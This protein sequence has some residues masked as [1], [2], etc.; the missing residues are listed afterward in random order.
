M[1]FEIQDIENWLFNMNGATPPSGA[2][3]PHSRLY[4]RQ[5]QFYAPKQETSSLES[6][7][8]GVVSKRVQIHSGGVTDIRI[9]AGKKGAVATSNN[10][11]LLTGCGF[12]VAKAIINAAGAGLQTEVY[13]RYGV[14]GVME[15]PQYGKDNYGKS[16]GRGY[17]IS[18]DS[19]DMRA[20]HNI[21]KIEMLTVPYLVG[22]E[23][24][25]GVENMYYEAFVHNKDLDYMIV[26]MAGMSHPL[27]E[28]SSDKSA[29]LTMNA[30]ERF[31]RDYPDSKLNLV[32]AIFNDKQAEENYKKH[33]VAK[34]A[35]LAKQLEAQ[36]K[37]NAVHD[38]PVVAHVKP[39]SSSP[40]EEKSEGSKFIHQSSDTDYFVTGVEKH[41]NGYKIHGAND[42]GEP[43]Y[44]I[45]DEQGNARGHNGPQLGYVE[46]QLFTNRKAIFKQYGIEEPK[47]HQK[48]GAQQVNK[49]ASFKE[50]HTLQSSA[51]KDKAENIKWANAANKLGYLDA[52][53]FDV[54]DSHKAFSFKDGSQAALFAKKFPH[55][56]T[57]QEGDYHKVVLNKSQ[58][59]N[60]LQPA[61]KSNLSQPNV[62]AAQPN[63]GMQS[64]FEKSQHQDK[65]RNI[66][67][68]E[69][70]KKVGYNN[71]MVFDCKDSKGSSYKEFSFKDG[72]QA[73]DFAKIA[74]AATAQAG[75]Y[76][77]VILSK[78]QVLTLQHKLQSRE[79]FLHSSKFDEHVTGFK[80][81]T[82]EMSANANENANYAKAHPIASQFC[83]GLEAAG[84]R[85]L[86]TGDK[87]A[88]KSECQHLCSKARNSSL[89]DHR[90][91]TGAI[92]KFVIDVLSV[93]TLGLTNRLSMFT[94]TDSV[95]KVDDFEQTVVNNL[96]LN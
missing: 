15:T 12:A 18:C 77:Q 23:N 68:A 4:G 75:G 70:I 25:D 67:L 10:G 47:P 50:A 44:V 24:E 58:L 16:E 56:A 31:V 79:A 37:Q 55:V 20:T 13:N 57:Y 76:H 81:K 45:I 39:T 51:A 86:K 22:K 87:Q 90:E 3:L 26:P 54:K 94:R 66:H 8:D 32:C 6:V 71:V 27:L 42:K 38:Q 69:A 14:P 63:A 1:K 59:N 82:K 7:G 29:R 92:A 84:R 5:Q 78:Q 11:D 19:Y 41:G 93:I 9:A 34:D 64:L 65:Q 89:K 96:S 35:I 21:D 60:L 61:I 80:A 74:H 88:L 52:W 33:V 17:A 53:V 72:K 83:S 36:H 48:Q 85:Y 40:V 95:K 28:N 2:K 62:V 49:W 43:R 73:A 91:W 30:F 46:K